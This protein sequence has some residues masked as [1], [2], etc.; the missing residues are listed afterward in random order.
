MRTFSRFTCDDKVVLPMIGWVLVNSSVGFFLEDSGCF[1][2]SYFMNKEDDLI[3]I[4]LEN[5]E[6][7]DSS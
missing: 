3:N 2:T 5:V 6:C 4:Y 7:I 1:V